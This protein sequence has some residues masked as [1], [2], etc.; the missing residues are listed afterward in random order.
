[1]S[2]DFTGLKPKN[3]REA[4]FLYGLGAALQCGFVGKGKPFAL[5]NTAMINFVAEWS[6]LSVEE[7]RA[8]IQR[9]F[10]EG[11]DPYGRPISA[12]SVSMRN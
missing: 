8:E 2:F 11:L 1:M 6:T 12:R 4:A 10:D 7:V 3:P 9:I 5:R